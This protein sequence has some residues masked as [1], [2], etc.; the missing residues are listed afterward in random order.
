[1][2]FYVD[3]EEVTKEQAIELVGSKNVDEGIY[4]VE[5]KGRYA[6]MTNQDTSGHCFQ[7]ILHNRH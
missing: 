6:W 3:Y 5:V 7:E 1:M 2:S 4:M